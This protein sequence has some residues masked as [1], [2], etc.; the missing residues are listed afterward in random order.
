MN[1]IWQV[2]FARKISIVMHMNDLKDKIYAK[3]LIMR[4]K[5]KYCPYNGTIRYYKKR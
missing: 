4:C 1:I 5:A 2:D 3:N